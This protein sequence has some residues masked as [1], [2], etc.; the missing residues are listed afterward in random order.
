MPYKRYT[1]RSVT[2]YA[3]SPKFTLELLAKRFLMLGIG[4]KRISCSSIISSFTKSLLPAD[5]GPPEPAAAVAAI[6]AGGRPGV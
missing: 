5:T 6:D 3:G 4:D 2:P 1:Y